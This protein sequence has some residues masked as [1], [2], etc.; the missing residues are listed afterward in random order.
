MVGIACSLPRTRRIEPITRSSPVNGDRALADITLRHLPHKGVYA[1]GV[2]KVSPS[3]A[4]VATIGVPLN[5]TFEIGSINKGITG[6][7]YVDAVERGEVKPDTTLGELLDLRECQSADLMLEE[8]SQHRSGLP[9]QS[10]GIADV[11]RIVLKTALAKNPFDGTTEQDLIRD[12]RCVAVGPKTPSYSNLGFAALGHA[13][14]SA[15]GTDYPTLLRD[16]IAET[17]GLEAF[18]VPKTGEAGLDGNAVQ[19]RDQDGR[20]QQAWTDLQ[21]AP[22]GGVRS[23]MRS[24]ATLAQKLLDGSAPGAASLDPVA[25]LSSDRKTRIGAGWVTSQIQGRTVTWHNGAT[26]GFSS[27]IGLDRERKTAI[28]IVGATTCPLDETGEALLLCH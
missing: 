9:N 14:A 16:R 22:A 11:A 13:L 6:M 7:L 3:G 26:G 18:Y 20:A 8:L 28:V 21:Y 27:W 17:L 19:G 4:N 12:L 10:M 23:N 2:A 5:S 1:L 24:M 15:A 25:D